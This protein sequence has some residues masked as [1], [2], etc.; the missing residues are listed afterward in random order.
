MERGHDL[1]FAEQ[2][3]EVAPVLADGGGG[4]NE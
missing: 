4:F 3:A 2:A 1:E